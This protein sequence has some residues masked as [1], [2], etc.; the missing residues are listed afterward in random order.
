MWVVFS[1]GRFGQELASFETECEAH[2][3]IMRKKE[4]TFNTGFKKKFVEKEC[5][6]TCK[7]I[8]K[9][10]QFDSCLNKIW[11]GSS[12]CYSCHFD[13]KKMKCD[14]WEARNV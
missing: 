1:T 9:G 6:E 12:E 14:E 11:S 3:Y 7:H 10:M 5:C 13:I 8:D 2:E 4:V